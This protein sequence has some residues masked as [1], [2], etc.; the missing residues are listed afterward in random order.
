MGIDGEYSAKIFN[1]DAR[2]AVATYIHCRF[3]GHRSHVAVSFLLQSVLLRIAS[4]SCACMGVRH[5]G[6]CL[7]ALLSR[8]LPPFS[9]SAS[10]QSR[11]LSMWPAPLRSYPQCPPPIVHCPCGNHNISSL[12]PPAMLSCRSIVPFPTPHVLPEFWQFWQ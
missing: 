9:L 4:L 5:L 11:L 6:L 7:P 8:L 1:T 3:S 12:Y 10:E 2:I